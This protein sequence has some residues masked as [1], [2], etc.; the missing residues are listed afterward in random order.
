[1]TLCPK[2]ESQILSNAHWS[3]RCSAFS[4][5]MGTPTRAAV[6]STCSRKMRARQ[7]RQPIS[8]SVASATNSQPQSSTRSQCTTYLCSPSPTTPALPPHLVEQALWGAAPLCGVLAVAHLH[9]GEAGGGGVALKHLKDGQVAVALAGV[10][11]PG[12]QLRGMGAALEPPVH[13]RQLD[14][15]LH[16]RLKDIEHA[17]VRQFPRLAHRPRPAALRQHLLGGAQQQVCVLDEQPAVPA[18]EEAAV[19][20]SRQEGGRGRRC[21]RST[22]SA[23]RQNRHFWRLAEIAGC[24]TE[25]RRG[26]RQAYECHALPLLA[27]LPPHPSPSCRHSF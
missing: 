23:S 14:A 27:G 19:L 24:R 21:R 18:Q 5:L 6:L 20:C 15:Q 16:C 9:A 22:E 17:A 1:M 11:V 4:P 7:E 3:Y 25:D 12:S 13:P 10:I 26:S 2:A 8:S